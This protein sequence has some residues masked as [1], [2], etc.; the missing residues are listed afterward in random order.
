MEA[1]INNYIDFKKLFLDL[2]EMQEDTLKEH[3]CEVEHYKKILDFKKQAYQEFEIINE[4]CD[5][6]SKKIVFSFG[7]DF[8]DT[9]ERCNQSTTADY[10]I[11]YD[12]ILDEFESLDYE[13]G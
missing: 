6:D 10:V 3:M 9:N 1:E 7:Y 11:V 5:Y 4:E 12:T 13:Q 8:G 2:F